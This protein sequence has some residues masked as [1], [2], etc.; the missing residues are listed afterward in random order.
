MLT[1]EQQQALQQE[2]FQRESSGNYKAKNRLGFVGGYQFGAPA[3]ETLGYLK[4]GASKGGNKALR[5]PSNWTDKNGIGSLNDFLNNPEVQDTAFKENLNFNLRV[6]K[7]K[8]TVKENTP[9]TNVAGF[10]AA[11][12]LLGPTAASKSL[13]KTDANNVTGRSYYDLGQ[14]ALLS[15][16]GDAPPVD[17]ASLPIEEIKEIQRSINVPVDGSWGPQSQRAYELTFQQPK[18]AGRKE[19][20]YED[21]SNWYDSFINPFLTLFK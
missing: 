7:Q 20:E 13:D 4:K 6:L 2:I 12:H 19:E 21:P 17:V 3:L 14:N 1:E 5:D 11:S 15:L 18:Q 10:L 9:A 16:T 8:G